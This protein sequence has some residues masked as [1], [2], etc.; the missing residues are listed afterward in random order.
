[1]ICV[2]GGERSLRRLERRLSAHSSLQEVRLDLLE[3]IDEE[4]FTVLARHPGNLITCRGRAAGGGFDGTAAEQCAILSRAASLGA[5]Y[6][7]VEVS[8]PGQLRRDL[9]ADRGSSGIVLSAHYYAVDEPGPAAAQDLAR[10]F[11]SSPADV[12]KVA[13]TVQDAADLLPLYRML[14][15]EQRPVVRIGM[16]QAGLLSRALFQR[17]GSPWTYVV[18]PGAPAVAPGQLHLHQAE[19]WRVGESGLTP[20]ALLGGPQVMTS[21]G[22]RVYNALF[23]GKGL[24]FIYLPVVTARPSETL[25][26]LEEL[27]FA[28][29]SVTMPAKEALAGQVDALAP[30]Q[31]PRVRAINTVALGGQRRQGSNTDVPAVQQ[32]LSAHAGRPALVL[33]AGGAARA[34]VA[35]LVAEACPTTVTSRDPARAQALAQDFGVRQV[36]WERRSQEP[37]TIL[38]NATP[39]G[40]GGQGDPLPGEIPWQDR[41]VLDA[42]LGPAPTPL[43]RRARQGGGLGISGQQWW[44]QQGARQM[45]LLTGRQISAEEVEALLGEQGWDDAV[46]DVSGMRP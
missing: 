24:P 6:V 28:G 45:S 43:L 1:M 42:V 37:F 12:L 3:R 44:V 27:G 25:E 11:N 33:G 20:L 8:V 13:L 15:H 14:R 41:V 9:H 46:V 40:S 16:G 35:A 5:R 31:D 22:P 26:L 2:T 23:A 39:C 17:F 4:V 19:S 7:D 21:P 34:A 29:C 38:V 30:G 10:E 18:A 32:L 36:P